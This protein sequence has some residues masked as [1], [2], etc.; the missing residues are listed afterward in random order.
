MNSELK[1][2]MLVEQAKAG[3]PEALREYFNDGADGRID[4]GSPGDFDD[5]VEVASGHLDN[6]EGFCN[7]RHEDATGGP[8]GSEDKVIYAR[9]SF[10]AP[11]R[12]HKAA[13]NEGKRAQ[14]R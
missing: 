9:D 4:W 5:C 1:L 11:I 10:G 2:I 6:P 7:L 14:L 12:I 13:V 3:N 8:P